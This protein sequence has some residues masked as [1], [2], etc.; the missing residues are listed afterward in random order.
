MKVYSTSNTDNQAYGFVDREQ[1]AALSRRG[2]WCESGRAVGVSGPARVLRGKVFIDKLHHSKSRAK[3]LI[4]LAMHDQV[5][6]DFRL[7]TLYL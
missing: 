4:K 3:S 1:L 2:Y 5:S 7:P 6:Q